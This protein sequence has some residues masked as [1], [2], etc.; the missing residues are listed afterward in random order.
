MDPEWFAARTSDAHGSGRLVP[1]ISGL[2]TGVVAQL[3]DDPA[4]E[5]RILVK[6]P[7]V[8]LSGNGVWARVCTMDAGKERG[9]FFRPHIGDEV[10]VGFMDDDPR[11]AIV[12]GMLHSKKLAAPLKATD[13]NKEKGFFFKS[14]MKM[15]FNEEV[16]SMT[17]ETPGGNKIIL[18]EKEKGITLQDQN[19]N[20][21]LMNK[22]GVTIESAAKLIFKASKGDIESEG[23]NIKAKASA[24]FKGEGSG[25]ME[26]T[27][28][29]VAKLKGSLVQIN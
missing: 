4:G 26:L 6:I 7:M 16:K 3:K 15:L 23:M 29:A 28:S 25:G 12:L 22:D 9:S 14:K 17:L 11:Q 20:K 5:H 10:L 1:P 27:S 18:S 21:I 2:H 13:E 24:Q 8:N 19:G